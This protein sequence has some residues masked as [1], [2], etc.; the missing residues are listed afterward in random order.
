MTRM[1]DAR[2]LLCPLPALRARRA[3]AGLRPHEELV[4]LATDP[5]APIDLAALA[6]DQGRRFSAERTSDGWRMRLYS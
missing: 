3:L 2:G 5:E 1:L 4:V 6:A